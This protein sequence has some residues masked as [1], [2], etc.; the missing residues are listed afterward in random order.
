MAIRVDDASDLKARAGLYELYSRLL[1]EELDL[2]TLQLFQQ[3]RWKDAL[4]Q[5]EVH[6]PE[7]NPESVE[8][9]AIDYCSVFIGPKDYCPPYQSVWQSGQLQGQVVDSM[10]DFLEVVQ[11]VSR[12][13]IEDHAG[14]QFEVMAQVLQHESEFG[15][16]GLADSFFRN[17]VSWTEA[18]LGRASAMAETGFYQTVLLSA[19]RFIGC[20][21]QVFGSS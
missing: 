19:A 20:E 16:Q 5:I 2:E 13:P 6:P 14:L 15:S 8:I 11:T 1:L 10:R 18:M 9:L 7:P 17:H 3:E 21:K 12:P 4:R